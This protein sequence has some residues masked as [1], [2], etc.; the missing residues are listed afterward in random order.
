[1]ATAFGIDGLENWG[2]SLKW[3]GLNGNYGIYI[4]KNMKAWKCFA[5]ILH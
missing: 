1:M 4:E 2:I 5:M 3:M